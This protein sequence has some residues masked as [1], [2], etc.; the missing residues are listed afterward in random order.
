MFSF[1]NKKK[2]RSKTFC[3]TSKFYVYL[4]FVFQKQRKKFKEKCHHRL[5]KFKTDFDDF[6]C[7]SCG[8]KQ[9]L[10]DVMYGCRKCDYDQCKKCYV[11]KSL[12]I[13]V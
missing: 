6:V 7:S 12:R 4:C 1:S 8:K 11:T 3:S 10:G 5:K 13:V 2:Q 9:A